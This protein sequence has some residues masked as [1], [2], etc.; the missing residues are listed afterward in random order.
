MDILQKF[1]IMEKNHI[2]WLEQKIN[3]FKIE[4]REALNSGENH[5]ACEIK[6][7]ISDFEGLKRSALNVLRS[8]PA[9]L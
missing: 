6:N 4:N 7:R 5:R 1:W 8:M 3:E 2:A 9:R